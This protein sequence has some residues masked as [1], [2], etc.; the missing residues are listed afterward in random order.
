MAVLGKF[1]KEL[2]RYE[3]VHCGEAF[4]VPNPRAQLIFVLW[5]H[6]DEVP[7][8]DNSCHSSFSPL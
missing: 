6:S 1:R 5:V 7:N 2:V 8:K 4:E 3:W